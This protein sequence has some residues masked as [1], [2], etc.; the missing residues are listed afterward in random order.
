VTVSTA[1]GEWSIP[2]QFEVQQEYV[3][4]VTPDTGG[5]RMLLYGYPQSPM[6]GQA[7]IQLYNAIPNT[8]LLVASGARQLADGRFVGGEVLAD[9]W[10]TGAVSAPVTLPAGVLPLT[11]FNPDSATRFVRGMIATL[12]ERAYLGIALRVNGQESEIATVLP[13]DGSPLQINQQPVALQGVPENRAAVIV[14]PV[15]D[16]SL[17]TAFYYRL[18]SSVERPAVRFLHLADG[19]AEVNV[20]LDSLHGEELL[21]GLLLGAQS[22]FMQFQRERRTTFVFWNPETEEQYTRL[23]NL[24]LLRGRAYTVVLYRSSRG[25]RTFLVQEF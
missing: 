13:V 16:T 15:Q 22:P 14:A 24:L 1:T 20:S 2:V 8:R 5:V 17:V 21:T 25:Y 10:T 12:Q 18:P 23:E 19:I 6:G 4:V 7:V 3:L 11:V 9:Q